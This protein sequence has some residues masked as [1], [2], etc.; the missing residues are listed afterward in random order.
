VAVAPHHLDPLVT[1]A[2][3]ARGNLLVA[4]ASPTNSFSLPAASGGQSDR[5]HGLG[6]CT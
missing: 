5:T 2:G 1:I 4:Q 6:Q 3:A